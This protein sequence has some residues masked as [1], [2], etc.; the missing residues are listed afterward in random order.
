MSDAL[1][2]KTF[3][4]EDAAYREQL[5]SEERQ[6]VV[7]AFGETASVNEIAVALNL[8]AGLVRKTLND[9]SAMRVALETKLNTARIQFFG[10]VVDR[11][12]E[13]VKN[14]SHENAINAAKLLREVVQGASDK[15]KGQKKP[16]TVAVQVNSY[17]AQVRGE[18]VIEVNAV[19]SEDDD[20]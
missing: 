14:G 5:T 17:E 7:S 4:Y 20:G 15:K 11:L 16:T 18:K 3:S 19:E 1:I 8:P 2:P 9:P 13:I 6:A 10:G 12:L